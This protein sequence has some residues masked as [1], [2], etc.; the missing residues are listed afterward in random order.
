M[1]SEAEGRA[2]EHIG[3]DGHRWWVRLTHWLIAGAVI[4]LMVSG[5]T[6]LMAHP[7]FYWGEAGNGLIQPLFEVPI[8]PNAKGASWS[9]AQ[10]FFTSPGGAV[11]ANRLAEPWNQ[12]GWARSLH[13]LAAWCFVG[14]LL[15]YLTIGLATGHVRRNLWPRRTELGRRNVMRDISEHLRLPMPAAKA[16]PPYG[17]LQ[18]LAYALVVVGALPLMVLTGMA[19]SPAITASY[20]ILLDMFGGTQSAR[21]IHFFSFALLGLFW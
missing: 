15:A 4:V 3:A 8:G 19:M 16:G 1:S 2:Q 13:F 10:P 14:G 5:F 7:R 18:K 9:P 21:T 11:T 17:I 20:P 6:I 12:N